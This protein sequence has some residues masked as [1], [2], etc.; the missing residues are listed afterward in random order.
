MHE[1]GKSF[2]TN[3][4]KIAIPANNGIIIIT[5]IAKYM[6]KIGNIR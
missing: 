1:E 6:T 2:F 4:D 3:Q 5:L